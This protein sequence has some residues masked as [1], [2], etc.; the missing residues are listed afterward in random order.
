MWTYKNWTNF[1]YKN[2]QKHGLGLEDDLD[3]QSTKYNEGEY[4]KANQSWNNLELS[5]INCN[6]SKN[7]TYIIKNIKR[8]DYEFIND[9]E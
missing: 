9:I 3:L 7:G 6:T 1:L 2:T 5:W 4:R 8:L